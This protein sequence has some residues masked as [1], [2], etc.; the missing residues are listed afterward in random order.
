MRTTSFDFKCSYLPALAVVAALTGA[1]G[2]DGGSYVSSASAGEWGEEGGGEAGGEGGEAGGEA[3]GDSASAGDPGGEEGGEAGEGGDTAG[4]EPGQLTAG[5]WRDLD[6]W[7][8]WRG[9]FSRADIKPYE[10]QW[11]FYTER[12]VPVTVRAASTPL[13]DAGVTLLGPGDV[14]LWRARTD[15]RGEAELFAGLYD[16]QGHE[17]YVLEVSSAG[18]L[19]RV[20]GVASG[21]QR[22][23]VDAEGQSPA[24]ALDLMLVV[25]TTGSMGDELGYLQ[26]ELADVVDRV[27]TQAGQDVALRLSVNFYRDSGD[28]YLVRA[29]PFTT[30]IDAAIADLDAQSAHGG[31]DWPEAVH[32]ALSDAIDQHEWS[33]S[34]TSRLCFIVLDAPP[35]EDPQTLDDIRQSVRTFA[36][37]GVRLVPIAASGVDQ[38]T[39]FLLRSFAVATG[40]TYTFLTDHSGIGGEHAEPTIGEYEIELLNDMLVRL[41]SDS[42]TP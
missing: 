32:S 20:E 1:C 3:G 36:E 7:S 35:H 22:I 14:P 16:G 13:A 27:R 8:F 19:Q 23:V 26:S 12:R 9:L 30:D 42:L 31:G 41:I 21:T 34:A 29:F 17:S 24:R 11:G 33:E 15:V 2:D 28:E 25:D 38:P 18:G 10:A 40:A 4:P 6:H 39:E 5:E 37:R